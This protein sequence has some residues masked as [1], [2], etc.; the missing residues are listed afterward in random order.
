M[1]IYM[2][3]CIYRASSL[4][5]VR[6]P[7]SKVLLKFPRAG[8]AQSKFALCAVC[9]ADSSFIRTPDT[10]LPEP[11]SAGGRKRAKKDEKRGHYKNLFMTARV[12]ADTVIS[13][14]EVISEASCRLTGVSEIFPGLCPTMRAGF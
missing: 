13:L 2:Y 14:A 3:I 4:S 11:S 6:Y 9:K 5:L 1:Y 8:L 7:A 12:S 10:R